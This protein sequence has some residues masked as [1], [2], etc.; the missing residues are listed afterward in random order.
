MVQRRGPVFDL[1]ATL[2]RVKEAK[3]TKVATRYVLFE[4][5]PAYSTMGYYSQDVPAK[6]VRVTDGTQAEIAQFISRHDPD[7]G[8]YFQIRT[9][10]LFEKTIT[11]RKWYDAGRIPPP[12]DADL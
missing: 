7:E 8:K 12:L 5:T 10:E 1:Q 11:T 3:G 9:E 6:F 4:V 2:R